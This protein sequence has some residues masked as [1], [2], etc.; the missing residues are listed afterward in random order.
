MARFHQGTRKG[1]AQRQCGRGRGG[2]RQ[3]QRAG[4][5][6]HAGVE[7]GRGVARQ[8]RVGVA[9]HADDG[10]V[11]IQQVR[12][13]AQQLVGLSRI[14]YGQDDVVLRD[15]AQVA[16]ENVQR[17]DEEARRTGRGQRGSDFGTDVPAFAHTR[18]DQFT[19]AVQHDFHRT[20]EVGV[21][22]RYQVQEGLR[23]VLQ[24]LD[25]G[26]S[27]LAHNREVITVSSSSSGSMFGPS[28]RAASGCGWVSKK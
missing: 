13:E 24:A 10:D 6:G 22:L 23:F 8:Q 18:D 21:E 1:V 14:G 5:A 27:P 4:L 17:V 7:M 28:L 25:G 19:L 12:Q 3:P 16:V 11:V 15:D 2:R 20:V 9:R 26:F